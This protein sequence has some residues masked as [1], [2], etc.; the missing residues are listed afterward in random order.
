MHNTCS[1]APEHLR[2][3][4]GDLVQNDWLIAGLGIEQARTDSKCWM[5]FPELNAP[6]YRVTYFHHCEAANVPN[7]DSKR[8]SS[9][10][11]ETT[12]LADKPEDKPGVMEATIQGL[13]NS[14]L[15]S[16]AD[17][18]CIASR[19]PIDIPCDFFYNGM[20]RA[21]TYSWGTR[22]WWTQFGKP[23]GYRKLF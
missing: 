3:A 16:Q 13:I 1:H 14:E 18:Y 23:R 5:Y 6:F 11:C 8:Y 7:G 20:V 22:A 2:C 15:L 17:R 19:Y 9:F 12:Y 4:A 21:N 10:M